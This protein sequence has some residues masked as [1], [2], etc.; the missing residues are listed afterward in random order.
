LE[1]SGAKSIIRV[2]VLACLPAILNFSLGNIEANARKKLG[3][4]L[5]ADRTNFKH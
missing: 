3:H 4:E 1:K 2:D 5:L